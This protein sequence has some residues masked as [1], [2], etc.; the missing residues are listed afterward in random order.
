M[1]GEGVGGGREEGV[2]QQVGVGVGGD[3]RGGNKTEISN[4]KYKTLVPGGHT[5][6]C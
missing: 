2:E 5:K 4:M 1:L 6:M 3:G